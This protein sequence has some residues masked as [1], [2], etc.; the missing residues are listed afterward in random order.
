[1]GEALASLAPSLPAPDA[2][3]L[4]DRVIDL[5]AKTTDSEQVLFCG[6]AFAALAPKLPASDVA[7]LALAVANRVVDLA[8]KAYKDSNAALAFLALAP[9]LHPEKRKELASRLL[10]TT[11]IRRMHTICLDLEESQRIVLPLAT[12]MDEQQQ[13][14]LLKHPTFVNPFRKMFI[15]HLAKHHG[16]AGTDLWGLVAHLEKTRPDLDLASPPKFPDRHKD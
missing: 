9:R 11:A 1:L 16:Y 14:D 7:R 2:S 15:A 8:P 13:L 4:A 6:K 3:A 10:S 12:L 5:A